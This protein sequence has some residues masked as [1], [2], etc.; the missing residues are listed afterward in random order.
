MPRRSQ[1]L[2]STASSVNLER[3]PSALRPRRRSPGSSSTA[4][5]AVAAQEE[6]TMRKNPLDFLLTHVP[7]TWHL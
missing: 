1:R 7:Q 5:V 3:L 2:S 4:F 6:R